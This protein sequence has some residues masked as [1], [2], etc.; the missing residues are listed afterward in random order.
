MYIYIFMRI[1][2]D[3]ILQGSMPRPSLAH[4]HFKIYISSPRFTASAFSRSS[5][6]CCHLHF[7]LLYS[8]GFIAISIGTMGTL[9]CQ[10]VP[11]VYCLFNWLHCHEFIAISKVHCCFNWLH[12]H[13][14]IVVELASLPVLGYITF[15]MGILPQILCSRAFT[16]D[17]MSLVVKPLLPFGAP[18][19]PTCIYL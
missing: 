17:Q 12:F 7:N 18:K 14:F 5:Q 8:H 3:L 13:E 19:L 10:L 15:P 2:S 1:H 4:T 6:T 9:P 16:F 11:R